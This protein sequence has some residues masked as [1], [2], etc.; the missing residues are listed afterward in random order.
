MLARCL[1]SAV[2]GAPMLSTRLALAARPEC[3]LLARRPFHRS[4]VLCDAAPRSEKVDRLTSEIA[5]LTLLEA[6]ELTESLKE[7]L[8]I[9]DVM[10][11]APMSAA[12]AAA[13][14]AAD[15]APAE[16]VVEKTAFNVILESWDPAAKIKVITEVR[17]LVGLGLKEAK[18]TVESA[19]KMI[20][21]DAKKAEAEEIKTKLEAVGAKIRLE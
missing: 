1:R 12:P 17:K 10:M 21:A 13:A 9:K 11:A 8:G 4:A 15:A 20:K 16:P 3:T 18:E 19:P 7:R 6:A 14:P 2:R 5:S